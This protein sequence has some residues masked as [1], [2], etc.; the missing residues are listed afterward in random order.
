MDYS[1]EELFIKRLGDRIVELRKQKGLSQRE[2]GLEV[3][4]DRPNFKKI[5]KGVTNPTTKTLL[6]ICSALEISMQELFDFDINE[7][8]N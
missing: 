7:V 6:R 5:E 2:L 4:W 1:N 3:G 8:K